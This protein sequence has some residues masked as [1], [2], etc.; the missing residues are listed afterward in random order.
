MYFIHKDVSPLLPCGNTVTAGWASGAR[1]IEIPPSPTAL[2]RA[3]HRGRRRHRASTS[4]H[5]AIRGRRSKEIAFAVRARFVDDT[6]DGA[7]G[8]T[9]TLRV[10]VARFQCGVPIVSP[11]YSCFV[12]SFSSVLRITI[13]LSSLLYARQ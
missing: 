6:S 7:F 3:R 10:V 1:G 4:H 9:T 13:N 12:R 2:E 11:R 5:R 8:G